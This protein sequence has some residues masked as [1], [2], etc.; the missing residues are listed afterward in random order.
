MEGRVAELE[1]E[2]SAM[3]AALR[4]REGNPIDRGDADADADADERGSYGMD[5]MRSEVDGISRSERSGS[6]QESISPTPASGENTNTR[7]TTAGTFD[8]QYTDENRDLD[9]VDRGR[10]SMATATHLVRI[11]VD[12]C[13]PLYPAVI[14]PRITTALDLKT[15]K[16]VL[17]LAIIAAASLGGD[18]PDLSKFLNQE[19]LRLYADRIFIKGEKSLELVQGLLITVAFYYPP[20][21]PERLQF[22]QYIHVAVTMAVDIGIG[23]VNSGIWGR[24]GRVGEDEGHMAEIS[25]T[26]LRCYISAA[27]Y[28]ILGY[29]VEDSNI[30]FLNIQILG[31]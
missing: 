18:D 8:G 31:S 20:G 7:A 5:G 1:R 10:V 23:S 29:W 30:G 24:G 6:T 11:Y 2:L 19:V 4:E 15:S 26:V 9:V 25:R 22:Y 16:P 12:H 28:V 27:R 17:F 21:N 3:R 14:L 13:M